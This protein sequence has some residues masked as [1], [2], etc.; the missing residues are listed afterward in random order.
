MKNL[1][2][3]KK[4]AIVTSGGDAPGMNAAIRSV[5][6]ESIYR[7][8]E[9]IGIQRGFIGLLDNQFADLNLRSV[10]GIINKGG[11]FLKTG[12]CAEIRTAK[13]MAKAVNTLKS[14]KIDGLIVIGGDGS[15][16]AGSGITQGGIPV[17]CIPGSIDNDI[18]GTDETIGFDTALDTAVEAI[19]KIRDTASSHDRVFIVEVMG[20][21]HGHLPL[22]VGVASGA[23]YIL[24]PEVKFSVDKLCSQ[25]QAERKKG[26]TSLIIVFAEGAGNPY[27]LA[28][29]IKTNIKSEV[30]VS[31]LGYIQRG[32]RPS[33]RSRILASRFGVHAVKTLLEGREN[34]L[35]VIQKGN[36]TDVPISSVVDKE[37]I[38][39]INLY[40]MAKQLAI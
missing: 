16:R 40:E 19:D 33:G 32:G 4:I 23:E 2:K 1:P 29:Q 30:R 11:T 27:K 20:R 22:A 28:E 5:V 8:I 15:L 14:L 10:S 38:F 13:G 7:G 36:I 17:V 6:R 31:S 25:L 35:V 26:K 39:D 21:E 18:Y 24:V 12:R 37:K 3:I 34:R 9:I